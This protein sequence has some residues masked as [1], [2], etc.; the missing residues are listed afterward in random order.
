ML[1]R[2]PGSD[3]CDHLVACHAALA[4]SLLLSLDD[5]GEQL[6]ASLLLTL[7]EAH[8]CRDHF[9]D[10]TITAGGNRFGGK[11]LQLRRQ[12]YAGH[13]PEANGHL[14]SR[15]GG[16]A[17]AAP[18]LCCGSPG[19][20]ERSPPCPIR[21]PNRRRAAAI[22]KVHRFNGPPWTPGYRDIPESVRWLLRR[23]GRP[24]RKATAF[25]FAM[26][27]RRLAATCDTCA[28]GRRDRALFPIGFAGAL[29]RSERVALQIE[30]VG[31]AAAGFE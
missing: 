7:E 28:R 19:Q 4:V 5:R 23:H 15:E 31:V 8:T 1:L 17:G 16:E 3:A 11:P 25:T 29:R 20:C 13:R 10:I 12:R 9:R 18:A 24:V 22:G 30:D 6:G 27:L 21:V 26:L 14:A 2:K